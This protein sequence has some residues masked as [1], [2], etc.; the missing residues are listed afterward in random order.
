MLPFVK[1]SISTRVELLQVNGH[2]PERP[3]VELVVPSN[4]RKILSVT[5]TTL[6]RD[7]G[8]ADDAGFSYSW[9]DTIVQRRASGLADLPSYTICANRTANAEF[10]EQNT[11]WDSQSKPRIRLWIEALEAGDIIG[12]LPRAIYPA[13]INIIR[14]ASIKLEYEA[15]DGARNETPAAENHEKIFYNRPLKTNEHEIRVLVVEPAVYDGPI[16]C[17]FDYTTLTETGSAVSLPRFDALSYCWD[18]S[19]GNSYILLDPNFQISGNVPWT[20]RRFSVGRNIET[21]LRRL[22]REDKAIRIWIDAMCINQ[23]DFEERAQQVSIMSLI[24]S[25]ATTVH[26][27]LGEGNLVVDTALRVVHELFNFAYGDCPGA[28]SCHCPDDGISKHSVSIQ[29]AEATRPPEGLA[30]LSASHINQFWN[31]IK[32]AL[33]RQ[34]CEIGDDWYSGEVAV[35]VSGL[36][37]HAWFTRVWVLQEALLARR[38][39]IHSSAEVIM[40]EE[41]ISISNLLLDLKYKGNWWPHFKSRADLAPIWVRLG[42]SSP[43][44]SQESESQASPRTEAKESG[45]SDL[46]GSKPVGILDVFIDALVMR[47]TDPRDKLFALLPFAY[48]ISKPTKKQ[49]TRLKL[50]GLIQPN[51]SKPTAVVLADFTRWWIHT[52]QSLAILSY[53]HADPARSWRR[54]ISNQRHSA[55]PTLYFGKRPQHPTWSIGANGR[56]SWARATLNSQFSFHATGAT[57][58]RLSP[59]HGDAD[60]NDNTERLTLRVDGLHVANIAK[61]GHFPVEKFFPYGSEDAMRGNDEAGNDPR[62]SIQT[63]FHKILDP[64]GLHQFWTL[65][66][67]ASEAPYDLAGAREFYSDHLRTHWA[68]CPRE[69]LLAMAPPSSDGDNEG[70][71]SLYETALLP[72]CLEPCFFVTTGDHYGLCPWTAQEGDM[73]VLLYGGNVPYLL[74]PTDKE[75]NV[76]TRDI[77]ELI[78]ECYVQGIMHGEFLNGQDGGNDQDAETRTFTLV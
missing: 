65:E 10:F 43:A 33:S 53:I 11:R 35:I 5:F 34:L 40:F 61:I 78:G 28:N 48:E 26:I 60:L 69:K 49:E 38:A 68:Y 54:M 66:A 46:V 71:F 47:A 58:P 67:D 37:Q 25:Y 18:R 9:F 16:H 22:R 73:I 4:V 64:C 57:T 56:A 41:A 15:Y 23:M 21:G 77:F 6:S 17:S 19:P 29:S 45:L 27:W 55:A 39:V 1:E 32:R 31:A 76:D 12:I 70:G 44:L 13:R 42:K 20:G 50:E 7:Q 24:Y 63:V 36:Y 74:R 30:S 62:Q 75:T 14:E 59:Q 72:T 52:H 3:Y 8:W 2:C 51:Y